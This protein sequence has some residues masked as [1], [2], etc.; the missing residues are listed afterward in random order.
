M[1][2]KE[3]QLL[4]ALVGIALAF[5]SWQ[6]VYKPNMEE[7]KQIEAQNQVV[8]TEINKLEQMEANRPTYLA[9]TEALKEEAQGVIEL[10]P[11]AYQAEDQIMYVYGM[12]G[13]RQ[14]EVVVPSVSMGSAMPIPYEGSFDAEG[15]SVAD[16]GI[17][18]SSAETNFSFVT[19]YKGL[20]NVVKYIYDM[21]GRKAITSVSVSGGGDGYLSGA[22]TV[23][24]YTMDG[25]GKE[26][27]PVNIGGVGLGKNNI[28]GSLNHIYAQ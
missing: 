22:M 21:P 9:D 28:F 18:L 15:Y 7:V 2:K 16:D 12:E 27:D 4:I 14:N 11:A 17:V 25:T 23:D 10:F 5:L 13:V 6:Y 24:F 26:Y 19:T 1:A 3:I 20:K 8:Q